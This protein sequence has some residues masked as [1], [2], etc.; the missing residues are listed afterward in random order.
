MPAGL[1]LF[2]YLDESAVLSIHGDG[3]SISDISSLDNDIPKI[4]L[5]HQQ[6]VV[7][8]LTKART[9]NIITSKPG[10]KEDNDGDKTMLKDFVEKRV[11]VLVQMKKLPIDYDPGILYA[12][13]VQ[14]LENRNNKVSLFKIYTLSYQRLPSV[15]CV[16]LCMKKA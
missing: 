9:M 5:P 8:V 3:S 6:G 4:L 1:L 7:D 16:F 2:H 15:L 12:E 14:C 13:V 10:E 11:K